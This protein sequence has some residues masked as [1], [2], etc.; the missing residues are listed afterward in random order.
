MEEQEYENSTLEY[1][2]TTSKPFKIPE[3]YMT[4]NMVS[5]KYVLTLEKTLFNI[6]CLTFS[7]TSFMFIASNISLDSL[8]YIL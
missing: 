7:A 5:H 3:E 4:F 1:G 6:F 8:Y 2:S